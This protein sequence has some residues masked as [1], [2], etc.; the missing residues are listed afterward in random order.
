MSNNDYNWRPWHLPEHL[1]VTNWITF[2]AARMIRRRDPPRPSFWHVSY[3]HPHPPLV[4]LASYVERYRSRPI[5]EPVVGD[6]ARD[7]SQL[8]YA[9]QV[10]RTYW[11]ELR[12]DRL[13]DARRAAYALCT[14]IDHQIRILIGSLREEAV[15]DNT[16]ILITADHGDMLGNHG[17]Y[18]KRLMYEG[19]ANTPMILIDVTGSA[20]VPSGAVDR[21]LVGLQDIMPT[22]LDLAGLPIP[23][24]CEGLSMAASERR[25]YLYGEAMVGAK[26]T[27]MIHDGR[28]KLIWYP[29]GNQLQLIDLE[30]DH[31]ERVDRS[32]DPGL[33]DIR[34]RLSAELV[35]QLY[36]ADLAW[37]EDGRLIGMP[38]PALHA[39]PNRDLHG[40]RG[41]HYPPVPISDARTVVGAG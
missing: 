4:P 1:H 40:Q 31:H 17:F 11:E 23:A 39:R 2:A 3:T 27:R 34:A 38:A 29:A 14:H 41:L 32:N 5:D 15:L 33:A 24:S 25:A 19:S 21:R 18:A 7:P 22:L 13:A 20:R 8:P 26:A 30:T 10:T 35:R 6:W 12:P 36:G 37:V 9:L 16:I 28:Y